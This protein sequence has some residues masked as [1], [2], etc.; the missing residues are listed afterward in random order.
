MS[1]SESQKDKSALH[2]EEVSSGPNKSPDDL[3][4][5]NILSHSKAEQQNA[6][7]RTNSIVSCILFFFL[8][9]RRLI[10]IQH[11]YV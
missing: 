9:F 4:V 3:E 11:L 10:E 6:E 5:D 2:L 7:H 8:D 1:S